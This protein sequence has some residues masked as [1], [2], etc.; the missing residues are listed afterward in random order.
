MIVLVVGYSGTARP[1]R[2]AIACHSS[3]ELLDVV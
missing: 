3:L 2:L 1:K